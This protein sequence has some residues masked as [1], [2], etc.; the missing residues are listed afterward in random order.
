MTNKF[1]L[2]R[3]TTVKPTGN[4]SAANTKE[5][6]EQLTKSLKNPKYS[7]ILVDLSLV[8]FIDSGGLM[9]LVKAFRQAQ[10]MNKRF[11]LCSIAPSVGIIFEL[12]QL[13]NVFEIFENRQIFDLTLK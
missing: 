4:L 5:L 11:S 7:I 8:N 13:N 2:E 3:M 12:T 10:S 1:L 6:Q 9:V